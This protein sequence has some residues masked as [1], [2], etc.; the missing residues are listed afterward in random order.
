MR[1]LKMEH[2]DDF[3]DSYVAFFEVS[4]VKP[5]YQKIAR[6]IDKE[7]YI[8]SCFGFCLFMDKDSR[9]FHVITEGSEEN[10]LYYIQNDGIKCYLEGSKIPDQV[11]ADAKAML[12][13]DVMA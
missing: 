10:E 5:E 9:S 6:R 7:N 4:D 8:D 1:L 11:I 12:F 3:D 2:F 13:D